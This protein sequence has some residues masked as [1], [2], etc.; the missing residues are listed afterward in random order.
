MIYVVFVNQIMSVLLI[1]ISRMILWVILNDN[2]S[3]ANVNLKIIL[4]CVFQESNHESDMILLDDSL[5]LNNLE[6]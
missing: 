5:S 6:W 4:W 1:K 3:V 2:Y